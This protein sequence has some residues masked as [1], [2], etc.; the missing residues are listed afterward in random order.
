VHKLNHLFEN[1]YFLYVC[2]CNKIFFL[3][4][5]I[6]F[7]EEFFKHKRGDEMTGKFRCR[8]CNELIKETDIVALTKLH[9]IAHV[10][11]NPAD[12]GEGIEK[13]GIFRVLME[14]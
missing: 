7:E 13:E 10:A 12:L 1:L 2:L 6:F 14:E 9:S 8:I 11:C 5:K 3:K 4:R